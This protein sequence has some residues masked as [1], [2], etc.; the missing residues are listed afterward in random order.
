MAEPGKLSIPYRVLA[1]AATIVALVSL[2]ALVVVS[3][4]TRADALATVALAL[5]ILAF[6]V[7]LIVYIVQS[8]QASQQSDQNRQLFNQ[9]QV[10]LEEI[11]QRA[12]GAETTLHT[13][14]SQL[15]DR[16]LS[17]IPKA[18]GET[19]S[20]GVTSS[21]ADFARQVTDN[22]SR[23]ASAANN[24]AGP[25][26]LPYYPPPVRAP[27]NEE[28]IRL[29]TTL[30]AN[31]EDLRRG[32][33]ELQELGEPAWKDLRR[34][35][36]DEVLYRRPQAHLRW[37]LPLPFGGEKLSDKGLIQ[38]VAD[39][40]PGRPRLFELT[41]RGRELARLLLAGGPIPEHLPDEARAALE[42]V[43]RNTQEDADGAQSSS[44]SD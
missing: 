18:I 44:N 19:E 27:D 12:A 37:G 29:L 7:Q 20:S 23:L 13:I 33:K 38:P 28:K 8:T 2:A 43:L 17:L 22:V 9:T 36:W 25:S 21:S 35:G 14:Q 3:T 34:F 30:P 32:L 16:M 42:A 10:M 40:P 41:D 26:D 6:V 15:L 31:T 4:V 1:I 24:E 5:A 11:S 39:I